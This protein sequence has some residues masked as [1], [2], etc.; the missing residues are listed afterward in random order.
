MHH[1]IHSY[2][3]LPVV[4]NKKMQLNLLMT[5]CIQQGE[6]TFVYKSYSLSLILN[7]RLIMAIHGTH[8]I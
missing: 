3:Y 1:P 8:Y 6:K 7:N 2:I 4:S 5:D